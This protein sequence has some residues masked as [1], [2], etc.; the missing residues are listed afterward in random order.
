MAAVALRLLIGRIRP[1]Y[2]GTAPLYRRCNRR[3]RRRLARPIDAF[4]PKIRQPRERSNFTRAR[5]RSPARHRFDRRPRLVAL[6]LSSTPRH[7]SLHSSRLVALRNKHARRFL[8]MF[9]FVGR[10]AV[11]A[12]RNC[13]FFLRRAA[14]T[15][16]AAPSLA[17]VRRYATL[18]PPV[19]RFSVAM[20]TTLRLACIS[21]SPPS[22][23][24]KTGRWVVL[25]CRVDG[26]SSK[27]AR[28]DDCCGMSFAY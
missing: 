16:T 8:F 11:N 28:L 20:K 13:E 12:L 15:P 22:V 14:P 26:E 5:V 24:L 18:P 17:L 19:L 4:P 9:T 21:G 23:P 25:R 2:I 10:P 7:P 3:R 6:V 27:L 1:R